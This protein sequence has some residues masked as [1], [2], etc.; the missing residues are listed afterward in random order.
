MATFVRIERF[1]TPPEGDLAMPPALDPADIVILFPDL[2]KGIV[3]T[4]KTNSARHVARG[5]KALATIAKVLSR[6]ALALGV[7]IPTPRPQ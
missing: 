6:P 4:A 5:A 3:E 2:Q 7:P 1:S